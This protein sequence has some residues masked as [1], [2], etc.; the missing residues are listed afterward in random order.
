MGVSIYPGYSSTE[1]AAFSAIAEGLGAIPVLG[2]YYQEAFQLIP[3]ITAG[4]TNIVQRRDA[5][6]AKLGVDLRI[7]LE[8]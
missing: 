8:Y 2:A 4:M 1:G 3:G 7:R 6:T 5:L